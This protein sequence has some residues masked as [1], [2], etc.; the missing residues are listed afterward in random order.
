MAR[1]SYAVIFD[2]AGERPFVVALTQL[3]GDAEAV[4]DSLRPAPAC[5]H[6]IVKLSDD[7]PGVDVASWIVVS[8]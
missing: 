6:R 5:R 2:R 4:L 1:P 7:M 8:D 3:R